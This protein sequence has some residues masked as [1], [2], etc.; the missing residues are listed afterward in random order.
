M[1]TRILLPNRAVAIMRPIAML[2]GTLLLAFAP[3]QARSDY[4]TEL[5]YSKFY[6]HPAYIQGFDDGYDGMDH[7]NTFTIMMT[8]AST[9]SDSKTGTRHTWMKI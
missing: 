4:K 8:A 5:R 1:K 6:N 7:N 2:A 9:T 3:I